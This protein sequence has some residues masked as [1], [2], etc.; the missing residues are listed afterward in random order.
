VSTSFWRPFSPARSV[1]ESLSPA[2]R[3]YRLIGWSPPWQWSPQRWWMGLFPSL[4]VRS[5]G[6]EQERYKWMLS[7]F[8][9]IGT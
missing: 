9:A 5:R 3:L 6:T 2:V 7:V 1:A 8:S 4:R